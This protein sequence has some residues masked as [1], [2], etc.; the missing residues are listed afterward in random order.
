MKTVHREK[1]QH[2]WVELSQ[3]QDAN[4]QRE[5]Y[6]LTEQPYT[7]RAGGPKGTLENVHLPLL[8]NM[9]AI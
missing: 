2:I 7:Q 5:V 3:T 1:E 9:E 4:P 8:K 6:K